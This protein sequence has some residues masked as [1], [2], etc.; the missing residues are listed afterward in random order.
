GRPSL[1]D[2][3]ARADVS[4]STVSRIVNGIEGRAA[5][6]TVARVRRAMAELGYR[7]DT[8]GRT[9]RQRQSRSVGVIASNLSNPVMTTVVASLEAA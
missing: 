7:P 8:A 1:A 6:E 4:I 5:P 9:L 2:V 3:A